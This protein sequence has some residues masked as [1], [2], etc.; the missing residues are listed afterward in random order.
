MGD[1][2]LLGE[3]AQGGMGVVYRARQRSLNRI[4]ALK[5]ILA[6]RLTTT[7]ALARFQAEAQATAELDHPHIVPIYEVGEHDGRPFFSM[8]LIGGGTF[9]DS[10]QKTPRP[11]VRELVTVL[12]KVCRAIH[13]AHQ[14]GILHRD[15][16]P[17]NVL[18]DD[19]GEPF[20]A[21]FGLVKRLGA[22]ETATAT[23]A[24]L[25]T[26]AYMAPEQAEGSSARITTLADVYALGAILYEILTGRPPFRGETPLDTLRQ[27]REAPVVPPAHLNPGADVNLTAVCLKCLEKDPVRRYASAEELA[28]DL[29]RWL[30]GEPVRARPAGSITRLFDWMRQNIRAAVW[31]ALIGVCW[32]LFGPQL[33]LAVRIFSPLVA[34]VNDAQLASAPTPWL[35][36][37]A[38]DVPEWLFLWVAVPIATLL[39][40]SGGM[41]TY[42]AARS[43]DPQSHITGGAVVGL[44]GAVIAYTQYLGPAFVLLLAIVPA[45]SDQTLLGEGFTTHEAPTTDQPHPQDRLL[46]RR[47]ELADTPERDRGLVFARKVMARAVS[48][49]FKGIALGMFVTLVTALPLSVGGSVIAGF[50]VRRA[51]SVRAA[52]TLYFEL[53]ALL[54]MVL[55]DLVILTL[56]FFLGWNS[57]IVIL[58]WSLLGA[59]GVGFLVLFVL[60]RWNWQDRWRMYGVV[61]A[62][63]GLPYLYVYGEAMHTPLMLLAFTP[64]LVLFG[65]SWVRGRRRGK[66]LTGAGG[67]EVGAGARTTQ[68]ISSAG[69]VAPPP[70]T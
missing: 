50:A 22:D 16:K 9:A 33:P 31:V 60:G 67:T 65:Y 14:R 43:R 54:S 21:D 55:S 64:A 69:T 62:V 3:L 19:A 18:L 68:P 46:E 13:F 29:N 27:V 24:L 45:T 53:F 59:L 25:G 39:H 35:V 8:K 11:P 28:D 10:L 20:V 51:G 17:S 37:T 57:R 30:V 5:M 42:L 1:Y 44:I 52:L 48:G 70:G 40:L 32:G 23:G 15:L 34:R 47:P 12:V 66:L 49:T 26:P 61:F 4:V 38:R 41:L 6:G 63:V 36:K 58:G 7:T 2:E 56:Y